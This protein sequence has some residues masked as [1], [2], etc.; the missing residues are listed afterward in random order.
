MAL[1]TIAKIDD[2]ALAQVVRMKLESEDIPVHLGSEGFA[3]LLGAQTGFSAVRVM[4][5][6]HVE[7]RARAVYDELMQLLDS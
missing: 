7:T 2:I 4:V 3:S 1:V 5:P 6:D